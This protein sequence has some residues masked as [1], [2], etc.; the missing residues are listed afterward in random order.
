MAGGWDRLILAVHALVRALLGA[1]AYD[2]QADDELTS[3]AQTCAVSFDPSVVHL[4]EV[5][6]ERQ[7][8]AQPALSFCGGMVCLHKQLKD[9]WEHVGGNSDPIIPHA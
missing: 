3:V 7:P 9:V 2:R 8:N 1:L 5:L 4:D 6:H